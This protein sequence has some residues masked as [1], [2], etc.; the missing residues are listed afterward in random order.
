MNQGRCTNMNHGRLNAPVRFCPTCGDKVNT[1]IQARCD[2]PKHAM[3]RKDRNTFC[4]D[5]G[6]KLSK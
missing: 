4:C 2:A 1:K 6:E 3:L 5:C